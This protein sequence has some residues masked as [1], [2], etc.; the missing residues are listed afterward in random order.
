[1]SRYGLLPTYVIIVAAIAEV[2]AVLGTDQVLDMI[3]VPVQA[4][5]GEAGLSKREI[6]IIRAG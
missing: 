5:D 3:Q 1:M 6:L 4:L 2:M